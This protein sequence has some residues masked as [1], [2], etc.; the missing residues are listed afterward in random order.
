M[1]LVNYRHMLIDVFA[2]VLS[3]QLGVRENIISLLWEGVLPVEKLTQYTV[4]RKVINVLLQ[5]Y[6]AACNTEVSDAVMFLKTR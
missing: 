4:C 6:S 1:T 2:F 3:S 5:T